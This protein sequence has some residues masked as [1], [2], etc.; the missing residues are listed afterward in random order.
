MQVL[1][2]LTDILPINRGHVVGPQQSSAAIQQVSTEFEKVYT[3]INKF[4]SAVSEG[5]EQIS[6]HTSSLKKG[7]QELKKA[8]IQVYTLYFFFTFLACAE[9]ITASKCHNGCCCK[10]C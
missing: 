2:A 10:E 3:S 1:S 9:Y 8:L 6:Q 4:N 5:A 7:F